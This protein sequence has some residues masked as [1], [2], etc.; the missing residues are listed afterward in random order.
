MRTP[1]EELAGQKVVAVGP[2]AIDRPAKSC[3]AFGRVG[4]GEEKDIARWHGDDE[5]A[6]DV[7]TLLLPEF[8]E[9]QK[10]RLE[11]AARREHV[12]GMVA[13]ALNLRQPT[14]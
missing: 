10:A 4:A 12:G 1:D 7:V 11:I 8:V 14:T 2:D 6:R 9:Q 3:E 5:V 13:V